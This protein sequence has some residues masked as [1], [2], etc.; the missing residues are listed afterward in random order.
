MKKYLYLFVGIV[1]IILLTITVFNFDPKTETWSSL[2][3]GAAFG[4]LL[5]KAPSMIKNRKQKSVK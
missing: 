3:M 1:A 2:F 4:Y 5:Y